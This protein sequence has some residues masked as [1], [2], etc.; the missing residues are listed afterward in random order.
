M[1]ESDDDAHRVL[2]CCGYYAGEA[3]ID[4]AENRALIIYNRLKSLVTRYFESCFTL[5]QSLV[6]PAA[7]IRKPPALA[8]FF[9]APEVRRAVAAPAKARHSFT[10]PDR[11]QSNDTRRASPDRQNDGRTVRTN[12]LSLA[13]SRTASKS[14]LIDRGP[15]K[16]GFTIPGNLFARCPALLGPAPTRNRSAA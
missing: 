5:D 3:V 9:R 8:G 16:S 11:L 1:T 6:A 15:A 10:R 7:R 14:R 2:R 12:P 13:A 4:I